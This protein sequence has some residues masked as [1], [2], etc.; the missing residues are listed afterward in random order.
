MRLVK[1]AIDVDQ[2][3]RT[4]LLSLMQK[5]T[6]LENPNSVP[7]MKGWLAEN[8]LETDSL[9]KKAVAELIKTSAPHLTDA[10][11]LRQQLAKSSVKKYQ[12]TRR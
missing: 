9:D 11:V 12:A 5:I 3:S 2:K 7:Q 10:L 6:S 8:G 1:A 4:E